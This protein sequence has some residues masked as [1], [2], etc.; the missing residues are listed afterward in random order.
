MPAHGGDQNWRLTRSCVRSTANSAVVSGMNAAM[1]A[2]CAEV[3]RCS[4]SA[5]R[6][7]QPK[8][9]P[10][11][12]NTIGVRCSRG[13]NGTRRTPSSTRAR[14]PAM[15]ARP[16]AVRNGLKPPTATFVIGTENEN[17]ST[18]T[19]AHTSPARTVGVIARAVRDV[20][21]V[22]IPR[23]YWRRD[24]GRGRG[25]SG[26]VAVRRSARP[27]SPRRWRGPRGSSCPR[28]RTA[29]PVEDEQRQ[30]DELDDE[31]LPLLVG[32]PALEAEVVAE[33]VDAERPGR[34]AGRSRTGSAA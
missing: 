15:T 19:N 27:R 24:P 10:I 2:T 17:S 12:V 9:A 33:P 29:T 30:R 26:L 13:G 5:S 7:G 31:V 18:P 25:A 8:T 20:P 3:V 4:A 34:T 23:M 6:I 1:T 32:L 14:A 11:I 22:A 16:M 28:P 21:T